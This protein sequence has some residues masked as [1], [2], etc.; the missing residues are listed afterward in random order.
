MVEVTDLLDNRINMSSARTIRRPTSMVQK[1]LIKSRRWAEFVHQHALKNGW[2]SFAVTPTVKMPESE[3]KDGIHIYRGS[4]DKQHGRGQ[5]I[6][7]RDAMT[8]AM[9]YKSSRP[10][11]YATWEAEYEN[12]LLS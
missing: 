9:I 2:E 10:I 1:G 12:S 4:Y 11:M 8:L 7:L 6:S 5:V 3:E